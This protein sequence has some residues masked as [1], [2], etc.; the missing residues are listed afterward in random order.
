MEEDNDL[1]STKALQT[2]YNVLTNDNKFSFNTTNN[3]KDLVIKMNGQNKI[4]PNINSLENGNSNDNTDGIPVPKH[5]LFPPERVLLEWKEVFVITLKLNSE[6]I[7]F[8]VKSRP[9]GSGLTNLGNTCFLNSVLQCLSYCPPLVNYLLHS[10]DH[11]LTKCK[12][13]CLYIE[14]LNVM[15]GLNFRQ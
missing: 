7:I 14:T 8:N 9:I 15:F 13:Y 5:V 11:N 10:N 6:Y 2:K 1:M 4:S 12:F 3:S